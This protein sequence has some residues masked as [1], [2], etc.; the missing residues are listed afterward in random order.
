[1]LTHGPVPVPYTRIVVQP[2]CKV[3]REKCLDVFDFGIHAA[4][5]VSR[6]CLYGEAQQLRE[7]VEMM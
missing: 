3:P 4:Q 5:A 7:G 1:M 6:Y 2:C